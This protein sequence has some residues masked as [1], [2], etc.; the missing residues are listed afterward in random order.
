[1]GGDTLIESRS[2][3]ITEPAPDLRATRPRS[4]IVILVAGALIA[5]AFV[6][7]V[8][9]PRARSV[10]AVQPA[11]SVPSSREATSATPPATADGAEPQAPARAATSADTAQPVEPV[12][13]NDVPT[14]RGPAPVPTH[15]ARAPS[16]SATAATSDAPGKDPTPLRT[17]QT[18]PKVQLER[19]NPW[20]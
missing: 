20:P 7:G 8:A 4:R 2:R 3:R 9:I 5:V 14:H 6:L 13:R 11:S 15:S 17:P 19:D 16:S 18:R 12:L 10:P 1:V